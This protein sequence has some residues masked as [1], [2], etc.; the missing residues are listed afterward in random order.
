MKLI[1]KWEYLIVRREVKKK[2]DGGI[3]IPDEAQKRNL[4]NTGIVQS[5][6]PDAQDWVKERVGREILFKQHS[7]AWLSVEGVELFSVHE[8]DIL[9]EVER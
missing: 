6:G 2:T 9:A 7:G 8:E 4:D 3:I 1:P 5:V